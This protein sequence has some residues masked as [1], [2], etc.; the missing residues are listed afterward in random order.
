MDI[1]AETISTRDRAK[2][3][4]GQDEKQGLWCDATGASVVATWRQHWPLFAEHRQGVNTAWTLFV[5]LF[6][7]LFRLSP[8]PE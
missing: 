1:P 7:W 8:K 6:I 5:C 3:R 2:P 4:P